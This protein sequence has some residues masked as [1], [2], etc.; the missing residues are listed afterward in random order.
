MLFRLLAAM[1]HSKATNRWHSI[2]FDLY[3]WAG[4]T[5]NLHRMKS[6]G[7][8]TEGFDTREA[9]VADVH[10]T[11]A[12]IKAGEGL[13]TILQLDEDLPWDGIEMPA[14]VGFL[15]EGKLVFI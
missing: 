12:R 11:A 3:P 4:D 7:H 14:W 2:F 9:A 5:E 6:L 10:A 8:H 15:Q 13:E 1:L